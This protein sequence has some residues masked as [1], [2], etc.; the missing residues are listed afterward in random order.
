MD[1]WL[2]IIDNM[3][4]TGCGACVPSCPTA[5]IELVS[6]V[7]VIVRP[8]GCMYCGR[9]EE[10]CPVNAVSLVYEISLAQPD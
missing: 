9:C 7:P 8:E 1:I 3:R 10:S 2:P 6:R 5:V 4:C